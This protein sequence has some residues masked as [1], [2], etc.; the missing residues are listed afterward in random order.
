MKGWPPCAL[1][2]HWQ[3][4]ACGYGSCVS[5]C[6]FFFGN[7]GKRST[8]HGHRGNQLWAY[9]PLL[10]GGLQVK[11]EEGL[12]IWGGWSQDNLLLS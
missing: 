1:A 3:V 12:N 8:C 5:S 9:T 6:H 4:A 2:Q 11:G 10:P 7:A